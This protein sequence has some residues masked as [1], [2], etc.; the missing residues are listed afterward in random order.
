MRWNSRWQTCC[1]IYAS[2]A[3]LSSLFFNTKTCGALPKFR[4]FEC[5]QTENARFLLLVDHQ[6][7]EEDWIELYGQVWSLLQPGQEAEQRQ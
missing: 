3:S 1:P 6:N 5:K 2:L 4:E 7:E